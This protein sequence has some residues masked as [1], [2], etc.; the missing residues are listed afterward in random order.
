MCTVNPKPEISVCICTLNPDPE[1]FAQVIEGLRSQSLPRSQWEIVLVDNGSRE[2]VQGR[3]ECAF[4]WHPGMRFVAEPKMGFPYVRQRAIRE[5]HGEI[6][7]FVD[8]D[9]ALAPDYLEQARVFFEQYPTLGVLT[10]SLKNASLSRFGMWKR[11]LSDIIFGNSEFEGFFR[12]TIKTCYTPALRGA[13][14]MVLRKA[15][16]LA[17]LQEIAL[18]HLE[19]EFRL[20]GLPPRTFED[21]DISMCAL[22]AGNEIGRTGSLVLTHYSTTDQISA[23]RIIARCYRDGFNECLFRHRWGWVSKGEGRIKP[24]LHFLRSVTR[25]TLSIGHGVIQIA[26]ALGE[27]RANKYAAANAVF[28]R[29][30]SARDTLTAE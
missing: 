7:V 4:S 16:G 29:R 12:T 8:D 18:G 13:A 28:A 22:Y 21:L 17:Y 6:I 11:W 3:Y 10:G 26:Y 25:P 1:V 27:L 30:R 23:I 19:N 24:Y 9:C 20:P 5:A 14:G 15:V 2:P